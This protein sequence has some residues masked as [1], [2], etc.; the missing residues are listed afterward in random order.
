M[1]NFLLLPQ[2]SKVKPD[3]H[4]EE[5]WDR[6]LTLSITLL[7][8]KEAFLESGQQT[9]LMTKTLILRLCVFVFKM[10]VAIDIRA[11]S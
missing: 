7:K 3:K 4:H 10:Y 6:F 11:L 9:D 5:L 2:L 8:V 1:V